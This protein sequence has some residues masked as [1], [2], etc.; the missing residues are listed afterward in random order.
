MKSKINKR[1]ALLSIMLLTGILIGAI[2]TASWSQ[3][4]AS[5]TREE[6]IAIIKTHPNHLTP[7]QREHR[8]AQYEARRNQLLGIAMKDDRVQKMVEG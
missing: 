4:A 8:H 5:G 6:C 7:E 3:K 1:V 2:V